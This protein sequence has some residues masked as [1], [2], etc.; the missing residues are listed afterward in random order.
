MFCAEGDFC[1]NGLRAVSA[2]HTLLL[3]RMTIN[4][5]A[6]CPT[7]VL[8]AVLLVC[9]GCVTDDPEA[10]RTA[11]A[12]SGGAEQA[13][14]DLLQDQV[15]AWNQGSIRRFME[16][17]AQTDTLRF[18]SGGNVWRGWE[19]TLQR[20]EETYSDE[21]LMGTLEF[22]DLEIWPVSEDFVVVFGRWQLRRSE[23]YT[24]IGGLFTLLVERGP[25]GWRIVHDHTSAREDIE[26]ENQNSAVVGQEDVEPQQ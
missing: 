16:G 23:S 26:S 25:D 13:V 4:A 8:V 9:T 21:G 5:I 10:P 11:D 24:N 17:Y 20:Y 18:A 7:L 6:D 15:D 22:S 14:R 3:S 1:Y 19:Q 12:A 2:H